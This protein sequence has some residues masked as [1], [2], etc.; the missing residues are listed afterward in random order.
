MSLPSIIVVDDNFA[1]RKFLLALLNGHAQCDAAAGGAEA[2]EAYNL[3]LRE[4]RQYDAMLLDI[5]M[6]GLDGLSVIRLVRESETGAGIGP[7]EGM[8]I[9]VVTAFKEYFKEAFR[10]GCDDYLLKPVEPSQLYEKIS[11][12][13]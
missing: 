10:A 1:N 13:T 6:P 7:G 4:G 12:I 2:L 3:S 5:S 11:S 8:R 9:I